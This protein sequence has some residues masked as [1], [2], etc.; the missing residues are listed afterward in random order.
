MSVL[1]QW[2]LVSRHFAAPAYWI[3]LL[4]AHQGSFQALHGAGAMQVIQIPFPFG[5]MVYGTGVIS[6]AGISF[7]FLQTAEGSI[8]QMMVRE[9]WICFCSD[10]GLSAM[11]GER[12]DTWQSNS[13]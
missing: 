7:T 11:H 10:D 8:K 12:M 2:H 6:V 3:N 9:L 5:K 1:V 4:I 13:H